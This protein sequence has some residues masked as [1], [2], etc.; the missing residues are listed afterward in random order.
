MTALACAHLLVSGA[1]SP[2]L[3]G[4][5]CARSRKRQC[6]P[7]E[8]CCNCSSETVLHTPVRPSS[9]DQAAQS[10]PTTTLQ[11]VKSP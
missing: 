8:N 10:Q 7:C 3:I 5:S 4:D 1:G 2:Q 6:C 9:L 11:A